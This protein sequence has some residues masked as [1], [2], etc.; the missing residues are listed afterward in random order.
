MRLRNIIKWPKNRLNIKCNILSFAL[1]IDIVVVAD[2]ISALHWRIYHFEIC[3]IC[4]CHC[5]IFWN[6]IVRWILPI[7]FDDRLLRKMRSHANQSLCGCWL[8][9]GGFVKWL[10]IRTSEFQFS[11]DFFLNFLRIS[12]SDRKLFAWYHMTQLKFITIVARCDHPLS[13]GS[14]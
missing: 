14:Q 7:N 3:D 10:N 2:V 4:W 8:C 5:E 1:I 11:F 13:T 9:V 12:M 6:L